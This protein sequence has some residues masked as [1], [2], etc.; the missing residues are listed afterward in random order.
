MLT[1]LFADESMPDLPGRYALRE[2]IA[3]LEREVS[4]RKRVYPR[5]VF[6]GRMTQPKMEEEIALMEQAVR[7]LRSLINDGK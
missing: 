1:D 5:Q 2:Q 6:K 7:T 4:M 3:C